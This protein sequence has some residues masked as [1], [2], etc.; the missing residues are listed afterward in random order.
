MSAPFDV[1]I[2][3]VG[4]GPAGSSTAL[5]L[6]RREGVAPGRVL[7]LD[8]ATHPREKPCAGAVSAWGLDALAAIGVR[9]DV[10]AAPMAGLRIL[11]GGPPGLHEGALGVVVRR[12]AFDA[13][14]AAAARR[15]GVLVRDGEGLVALERV[16]GGFRLHTS[17]RSWT[18]RALA[19]CDGS[20]SATRRLLAI[21]EV[22]RKGH[23]YVLETEEA[24][25]DAG[26]RRDLCDFDL[27]V[28]EGGLEGYYW[29][30]PARIGG[31]RAVSRGIYHANFTPRSDVKAVLL[32][33]LA[34]RGV[35]PARVTLKPWSTRP[36]VPSSPLVAGR[37]LLVGEAAGIDRTTGEGIAQAILFGALAARHLAR[38]AR[39]P[40]APLDGYAEDVRAS[41]L[42]RHLLQ[43]AWLAGRVYGPSG[44]P[45]R[46]LL[47]TSP[48][49]RAAGAEW[50]AGRPLARRSK[51]RL[52]AGLAL[53]FARQRLPLRP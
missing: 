41:R 52:A 23:L 47:A 8:K 14:L 12:D 16:E 46:R 30:F 6:V 48:H 3:I 10:P 28:C 44:G 39:D 5:H 22:A 37:A 7:V 31:Q 35:D 33:Y 18:A 26:V 29:D 42:A 15:D 11:D 43:S 45:W 24:P 36:F 19:A 13:S 53:A 2:A 1:D 51:V 49:A 40:G 32:R 17:R 27:S 9:A 21:P 50:Y 38:A 20:G 34:R 25:G 4:A